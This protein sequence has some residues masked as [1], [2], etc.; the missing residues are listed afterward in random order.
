MVVSFSRVEVA[1]NQKNKNLSHISSLL[2]WVSIKPQFTLKIDL[3]SRSI[4]PWLT[5]SRLPVE[6][7]AV[8]ALRSCNIYSSC[9]SWIWFSYQWWYP[10]HSCF[11]KPTNKIT[12]IRFTGGLTSGLQTRISRGGLREW[13]IFG[14]IR[15][16]VFSSLHKKNIPYPTFPSRQFFS[17]RLRNFWFAFPVKE[18][19]ARFITLWQ[20]FRE[21]LQ[22]LST[23]KGLHISSPETGRLTSFS[24]PPPSSKSF[25][26]SHMLHFPWSVLISP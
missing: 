22:E 2:Q 21:T 26:F 13:H 11:Y 12:I 20:P 19:K 3:P 17:Y 6:I 23:K 10:S 7:I 14:T 1:L 15:C 18:N 9:S 4:T 8:S 24:C 16:F 5:V 25:I